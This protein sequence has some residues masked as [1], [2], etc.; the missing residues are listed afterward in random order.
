MDEHLGLSALQFVEQRGEPAVAEV[1]AEG[2]AEQHDAVKVQDIEG[3]AEL[4][5]G[6]VDVREGEAGEPA[7]AV[8]MVAHQVR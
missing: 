3:V 4:V 6:A 2:V 5:E 1:D 8:R 7:E